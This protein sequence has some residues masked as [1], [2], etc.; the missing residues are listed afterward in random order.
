MKPMQGLMKTK[1]FD[2]LNTP[3]NAIKALI[4]FIPQEV[5]V[6]WECCDPGNSLIS[7]VLRENNYEVKS[8]DIKSGNNFLKTTDCFCDAIVTN[9]PFSLKT[10]FLEKCFKLDKPFALLLPLTSLG[11]QVRNSLFAH[12]GISVIILD[13]RIDFTGKGAP[14]FP[15]GW[16]TWKFFQDNTLKFVEV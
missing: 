5:G 6:I 4:P 12:Y 10:K 7:T 9:P 2:D 13:K 14:W 15:V 16:F 1:S 8:S 11:G 3:L